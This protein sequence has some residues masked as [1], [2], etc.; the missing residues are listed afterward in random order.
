[1]SRPHSSGA[2]VLPKPYLVVPELR[3]QFRQ[4]AIL[5]VL[6]GMGKLARAE[7]KE[8]GKVGSQVA[9]AGSSGGMRTGMFVG[10]VVRGGHGRF[11]SGLTP[12]VLAP[13]ARYGTAVAAS[14][15]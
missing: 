10:L 13:V 15:P 1:M 12:K 5:A 3:A 6:A 2:A 7:D 4:D 11:L 9:T 14:F 8:G